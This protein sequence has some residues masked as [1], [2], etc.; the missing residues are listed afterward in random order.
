[1]QISPFIKLIGKFRSPKNGI[2]LSSEC[3][4]NE[5]KK[6][7]LHIDDKVITLYLMHNET[8]ILNATGKYISEVEGNRIFICGE[9]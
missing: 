6:N 3:I 8:G 5:N 7:V 4:A 9:I 2:T 1:M